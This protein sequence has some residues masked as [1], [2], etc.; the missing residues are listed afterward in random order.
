MSSIRPGI[1]IVVFLA[2]VIAA[3]GAAPEQPAD[4][5]VPALEGVSLNKMRFD[6]SSFVQEHDDGRITRFTV[7][8]EMQRFT[9]RLFARYDVPA[10]AAVMLNS[11]TGRVITL[12]QY[13]GNPR[14]AQIPSVAFDPSPPAASL[15]KIV[16]T[17]A[18][19]ERGDVTLDTKTCYH[20]G[21]QKLKIHNL[22][23]SQRDDAACASLEAALG[24]SIN[25][26]FAKLSDRNLDPGVLE[27]YANRFGF[28]KEIPFDIAIGKSEANVPN[29]RLERARAAAGFW[30]THLSPI[31]AAVIAQAV[32]QGGA[33]LR[34]YIIDEVLDDKGNTIYKGAP[35]FIGRPISAMTAKAL[36][37]A[38][39]YTVRKGT[40]RKAFRDRAGASFLPGMEVAGK[41]GTL[42]GSKPYRAYSWFLAIAPADDPE[43]ALSVLVVNEP[44]WRIKSAAFAAQ[45]LHKYFE[46]RLR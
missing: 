28:N 29:D 32:A 17:S 20:G 45:L 4:K 33:M 7:D 11:R 13:L 24:R 16:T 26:I 39:T 31:H 35:E 2:I 23:D 12:S 36:R 10:G 42:N 18:L 22:E 21:S 5:S 15:F 1:S 3:T 43:V 6:G 46:D 27:E 30:H 37:D 8:P 25:S 44:K 41:T 9:D 14:S 40:A 38:M 34:P 19:L